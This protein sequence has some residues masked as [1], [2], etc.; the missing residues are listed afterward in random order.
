MTVGPSLH[1]HLFRAYYTC[2]YSSADVATK[3]AYMCAL[4]PRAAHTYM[5]FHGGRDT[6]KRSNS[7]AYCEQSPTLGSKG[8]TIRIIVAS[9]LAT[10]DGQIRMSLI[11][12]CS[13]R[14]CLI[15]KFK[16]RIQ[17][18]VETFAHWSGFCVKY[19]QTHYTTVA[20][21]RN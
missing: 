18:S 8:S 10:H 17:M 15:T 19:K 14:S 9:D 21:R 4:Q 6:G 20:R 1:G 13:A 2:C 11:A 7:L 5:N 12:G 3:R 16:A